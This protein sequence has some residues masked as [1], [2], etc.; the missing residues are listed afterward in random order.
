MDKLFKEDRSFKKLCLLND[1]W[2]LLP[3]KGNHEMNCER[4]CKRVMQRVTNYET[5]YSASNLTS[6]KLMA[7][8]LFSCLNLHH[9]LLF[10]GCWTG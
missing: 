1:W 5:E 9:N 6:I 10:A 3:S 2:T 8:G 7:G 4:S